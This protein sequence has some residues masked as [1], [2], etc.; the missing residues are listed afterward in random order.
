MAGVT[1]ADGDTVRVVAA[2]GFPAQTLPADDTLFGVVIDRGEIVVEDAAAHPLFRQLAPVRGASGVR[3]F[4]GVPFT[5]A[6]G[7]AC[8]VMWV[9][10]RRP[11][12]FSPDDLTSLRLVAEQAN[13]VI[14]LRDAYEQLAVRTAERDTAAE[15]AARVE[16]LLGVAF[17][18][19]PLP[20]TLRSLDG[21]Y[22]R[23][24]AAGC[25]ILGYEPGQLDGRALTDTLAPTDIEHDHELHQRLIAGQL[26]NVVREGNYRHVDGGLVRLRVNTALIRGSSGEPWFFFSH[27]EDVT[28]RRRTEH[29][30]RSTQ[31][32]GD[33]I[34]SADAAGTITSWNLA[35][36]RM[37]GWTEQEAV[38]RPLTILMSEEHGPAQLQGLARLAAGGGSRI[39]GAPL[40]LSALCRDGSRLPVE[41]SLAT[42]HGDDGGSFHTAVIRDITD[43]K[44]IERALE[45]SRRQLEGVLRHLPGMAYRCRKDPDWPLEFVSPGAAELTGYSPAEL[46]GGAVPYGDLIDPD[47]RDRVWQEVSAACAAGQ[48]FTLIYRIVTRDGSRKWVW[49][50]GQQWGDDAIDGY[51][52]DISWLREARVQRERADALVALLAEVAVAAAT[53]DSF[54]DVAQVAL[55]H[56]GE[57]FGWP[58]AYAHLVIDTDDLAPLVTPSGTPPVGSD[59]AAHVPQ[60][61]ARTA[62]AA[63][64]AGQPVWVPDA[65][66]ADASAPHLV[67]GCGVPILSRGAAVAVLT[68]RADGEDEPDRMALDVLAQVGAHLGQVFERRQLEQRLRGA[69]R[70][71]ATAR[72]R[73]VELDAARNAILTAMNHELRTPLTITSGVL[74]LLAQHGDRLEPTLRDQLLGR[75]IAQSDRLE[76]LVEDALDITRLRA[77][78]IVRV[79]AGSVDLTAVMSDALASA[80]LDRYEVETDLGPSHAHGD[81]QLLRR[82]LDHV[83]ANVRR[84]TPPGTRVRITAGRRGH[85]AFVEVSDSGPGVPEPLRGRVVAPFVT[86]PSAPAHSPG[87]GLGLA[88]VDAI[89]RLHDGALTIGEPAAGGTSVRIDLPSAEVAR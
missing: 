23:V 26:D 88:L 52:T 47:D 85:R 20:M 70:A 44:E 46:T 37:F 24:N 54:G 79:P 58:I 28:A 75:A 80:G 25:R 66:P 60:A 18:R 55:D 45:R 19:S 38:G 62:R 33:A 86:G 30:L 50:R 16:Q 21:H 5:D 35:A 59:D 1:L 61:T 15:A 53:R 78:G 51:V 40:E 87:A 57:A 11:R 6:G 32:A 81:R 12:A 73:L 8:G 14:R 72:E 2:E 10:D 13:S 83:L 82:A 39:D 36:E 69:L 22:L 42:W 27:A 3:A 43:R 63:I 7:D 56:I 9:G 77:P 64:R 89:V 84:H 49:E 4:A 74:R 48:P 31:A 17:D 41:L 68:F 29:A 76:R 65:G 67:A 34:V 71:E